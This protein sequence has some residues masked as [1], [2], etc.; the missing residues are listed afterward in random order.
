MSVYYG[1]SC[2]L[3]ASKEFIHKGVKPPRTFF[4][5][6]K[7]R[8]AAKRSAIFLLL[9][10]IVSCLLIVCRC[11]LGERIKSRGERHIPFYTCLWNPSLLAT[12]NHFSDEQ[13]SMGGCLSTP[14]QLCVHFYVLTLDRALI[15]GTL[16]P[17]NKLKMQSEFQIDKA[18]QIQPF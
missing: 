17:Q 18:K 4:V 14:T 5:R 3:R 13:G 12:F 8:T 10:S 16:R 11:V 7:W 9:S 2:Q 15:V 6:H 1:I